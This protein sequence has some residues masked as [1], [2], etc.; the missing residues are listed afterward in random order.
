MFAMSCNMEPGHNNPTLAQTS[1]HTV[2]FKS[3]LTLDSR[4]LHESRIENRDSQQT[5]NLF[6][7]GTVYLYNPTVTN[8]TLHRPT[9]TQISLH[10][11]TSAYI[12][13]YKPTQTYISLHQHSQPYISL[14][15]PTQPYISLH[16]T[17]PTQPYRSLH[18]HT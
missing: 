11:H 3:K 18:S 5:V 6:L 8:I 9:Q 7:N 10:S 14:H 1:L 15:Q 16:Q 17:W 13:L 12:S 2:P 4:S